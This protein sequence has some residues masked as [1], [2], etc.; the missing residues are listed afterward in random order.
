MLKIRKGTDP[1]QFDILA[2]LVESYVPAFFDS[3]LDPAEALLTRK[4]PLVG[5]R[6]LVSGKSNFKGY[7]GYVRSVAGES[8]RL[9]MEAIAI[10]RF[11]DIPSKDVVDLYVT[12]IHL[13]AGY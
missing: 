3:I 9:E 7:V 8:V 5:R 2:R 4:Y 6:V 10:G 1:R 13:T 12:F 11:E